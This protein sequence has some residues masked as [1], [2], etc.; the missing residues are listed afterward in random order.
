M[1]WT[2]SRERYFALPG[3]VTDRLSEGCN[4]LIKMGA[5]LVTNPQ[6][7]LEELIPHYHQNPS[8]SKIKVNSLE[9]KE[10]MVYASLSFDPKHIEDISYNKSYNR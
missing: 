5:K 4:N 10:K 3:R 9:Q 1:I 8:Q 2:R 6:E 7:V